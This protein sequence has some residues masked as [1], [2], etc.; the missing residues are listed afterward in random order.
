MGIKCWN[1]RF[2]AHDSKTLIIVVQPTLPMN[3][4]N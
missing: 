4:T 2:N 3:G 1:L